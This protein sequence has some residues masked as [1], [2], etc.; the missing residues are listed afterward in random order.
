MKENII[1]YQGIKTNNLKNINLEIPKG[2]FW[3]IAGPSG[4][5]KSSLAYGTIYAISQFEWDKISNSNSISIPNFTV[6]NYKNIIP[7]IALKQ[8]NFNVNPRST[9][10]TFLKIDKDFR[11]LLSSANKV[12]P[13]IFSFNNP[14][15]YCSFCEGLGVEHSLST[16]QIIDYTKS[17][18]N[19]PF[20]PWKKNYKQKV[21]E[22]F[23][24]A[25]GISVTA[26]LEDLKKEELEALLYGKSQNKY[27]V[28]YTISGK[29]RTREF[30]YLGLMTE[31][32]ALNNDRKHISN[33][34]KVFD[35]TIMNTCSKCNGSRFSEKVLKY[36]Y[37]GKSIG[38]MYLSEFSE[39]L[40]FINDSLLI[41]K[42]SDLKRLLAN[43]ERTVSSM[44]NSNLS[45]L[46]LN[47]SIPT[48]SGG[49]LQRIRL[50]NILTSQIS[51]MLYIVDEPSSK[52]HVSEYN[53]ILESLKNLRDNQNSVL[54]IE[55]N[56]YFLNRTEKTIYLGPG[57]GVRG[58]E[59]ISPVNRDIPLD[60]KPRKCSEF[61]EFRDITRNNI[62]NLSI[63]IPFN[64]ITSI[65][66]PSGSGKSTLAKYISENYKES[67]FVNQ[68]PIRG[69]IVSTIASYSGI[70][71]DIRNIFSKI[72]GKENSFFSFM[73]EEG[74]CS[75]CNGK[76]LIKYGLDFGKT[77][78]EIVCEDCKGK[79]FN[80]S[81]L[82]VKYQDLSIYDILTLT[83]DTIIKDELFIKDTVLNNK[84]I[85]LQKLGL[86]YL[87][88]FR[89]TDSL[90][91]GEAQ[92][93][94][95]TKFIGK[96]LKN[97]IFIFDEPLSGLSQ[98]D[99]HNILQVFNE[100][101]LKGATVI[102]IDHNILGIE[103]SDYIIEMGPGKGKFGGKVTFAGDI[104]KFK[105]TEI[106]KLYN[107]MR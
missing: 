106:F 76:G 68:K 12:S 81:S 17:I 64:C 107:S 101:V 100:L 26:K 91:G 73:N 28:S 43:I 61:L 95:L 35:Y 48:L 46:N 1:N 93:L 34:K 98:W 60:Y 78:I 13:T 104:L 27:K 77:E 11:L 58:G 2:C 71:D 87:N 99:A 33:H 3:S 56:P 24:D 9:I 29:K 20:L 5:G 18:V 10:A 45:Y 96:K 53:S 70:F 62:Q 8:E 83:I 92:R 30:Y 84:L 16:N 36:K 50:V 44:V 38:D 49:E 7:A 32:E 57:S 63:K 42:N 66:G 102:F 82:N 72:S 65:Y 31:M 90:S 103:F 25:N 80:D 52:L 89:T 105:N 15:N 88:L 47:R 22:K 51:G 19:E 75:T 41:E 40:G 14:A 54:V 94:K 86:G 4:S 39:L 79:R 37:N 69:S 74:Q 23:A 55:H 97:K 6:D 67:E 59:I 21:L 85:L